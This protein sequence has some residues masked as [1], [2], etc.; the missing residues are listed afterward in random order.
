MHIT[1][2]LLKVVICTVCPVQGV[3]DSALLSMNLLSNT[4]CSNIRP[5]VNH[6]IVMIVSITFVVTTE[7][8]TDRQTD[9]QHKAAQSCPPVRAT[10]CVRQYRNTNTSVCHK[11]NKPISPI[12]TSVLSHCSQRPP[13]FHTHNSAPAVSALHNSLQHFCLWTVSFACPKASSEGAWD[14][15]TSQAR[16]MG[17]N[18]KTC[19]GAVWGG[20]VTWRWFIR[21][22][23]FS[24]LEQ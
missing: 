24:F 19:E 11:M 9:R 20:G 1:A 15:V 10:L 7:H 17:Q 22:T 8:C 13:P 2:H 16:P 18:R 5:F 21:L 23:A 14:L 12:T 6:Y 4:C 3:A